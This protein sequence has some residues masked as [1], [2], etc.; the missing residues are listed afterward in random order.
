VRLIAASLQPVARLLPAPY[1]FALPLSVGSF[2]KKSRAHNSNYEC[3]TI[4][5]QKQYDR[6][7]PSFDLTKRTSFGPLFHFTVVRP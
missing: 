1:R 4:V 3:H 6:V 5:L 7:V 2:C